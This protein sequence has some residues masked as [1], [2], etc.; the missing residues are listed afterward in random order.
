MRLARDERRFDIG[1]FESYFEA[2][3]EF[4]INDPVYGPNLRAYVK[5]LL[6]DAGKS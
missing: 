5:S 2:F 1:N 3:T 4:A 6:G